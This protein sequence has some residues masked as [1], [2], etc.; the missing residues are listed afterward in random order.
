MEQL[1]ANCF[2]ELPNAPTIGSSTGPGSVGTG[3]SIGTMGT[4]GNGLGVNGK[5]PYAGPNIYGTC[6]YRK[7][8]SAPT[9]RTTVTGINGKD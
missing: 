9:G 8:L 4:S 1:K 3:T 7:Y 5:N 2:L 6:P